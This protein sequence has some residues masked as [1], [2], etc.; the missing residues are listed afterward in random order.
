MI[1][2]GTKDMPPQANEMLMKW[3]ITDE[4]LRTRGRIDE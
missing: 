3:R 1:G 2:T 4:T